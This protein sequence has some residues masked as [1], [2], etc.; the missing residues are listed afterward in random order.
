[1]ND[2]DASESV[3][4]KK[5]AFL[6]TN[7][8][9]YIGLY[10]EYA[11]ENMLYPMDANRTEKDKMA[12]KERVNTLNETNLQKRLNQGLETVY[13]L[14]SNDVQT[15]YAPVSEL[16]L[17]TG[18]TKGRAIL[19]AADEG[20]P[21]RMWSRIQESEIRDRVG[22]DDMAEIK[23]KVDGLNTMLEDSGVAVKTDTREGANK[24]VMDLA[25]VINGLV[26]MSSMDSIIYASAL[27]A[28]SDYLFTTD[29][30][31]RETVNNIQSPHAKTPY[32]Y[33]RKQLCQFI[34]KELLINENKL[35][36][37]SA[38]QVLADGQVNP[39]FHSNSDE[40]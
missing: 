13:V 1:M 3:A 23:M 9:H 15:Q 31:L 5:V 39:R 35:L 25:K 26:Y 29:D 6:D 11:N 14:L 12:A 19:I 10:L 36:L 18:K 30:Y 38:H 8:L 7:T 17:L 34:S 33:I 40:H 21:E 27:V 4:F 37:P 28:Q 20:V 22:R 24:E 16:E 32:E 2:S